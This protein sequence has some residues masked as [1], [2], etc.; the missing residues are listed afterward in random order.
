M[1]HATLR[2]LLLPAV[3]AAAGAA[4]AQAP[5]YPTQ[6]IRIVVPYPAGG[7]ADLMAR[8]VAAGLTKIYP[9]PVLVENR[10]GGG[11]HLGAE[12]VAKAA[13]DGY[14]LMLG[15]IS[16][17]GAFKMYKGL[18]YSP[19][20]DLQ[21]I[22]LIAESFN[23]LMVRE[24][25]PVKSVAEL[26]ALARAQPGKL[27]YA[28]AGSGSATHMAAELFKYMTKADILAI[29]FKG[30]APGQVA[31]LGGHVDMNFETASTALAAIRSGKVRAL[32]VTSPTRSASFPDLPAIADAGVPGYAAVPWYTIST[33]KGVPAPIVRKLNA[34]INV[35]VKSPELAKRWDTLGLVP[36]GGTPQD[37][38]TRNQTEIKRWDAV[39][40]AAGIQ[41]N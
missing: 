14:T 11:G 29:P 23:V 5:S 18:R 27:T 31:L 34:D 28:S 16:H 4:F 37:A 33:S 38:A 13:A 39:I 10:P 21:S 35:L 32:G 17:H 3:L 40:D 36:L 30:G 8:D 15:T 24:S 6:Q 41:V 12:Y 9:Q 2:C 22:I 7:S 26:I 20:N 19:A 25:L 1:I